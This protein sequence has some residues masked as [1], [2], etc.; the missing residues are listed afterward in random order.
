MVVQC[1]FKLK[2]L[3]PTIIL[4]I[5]Y[6]PHTSKYKNHK[7]VKMDSKEPEALLYI[8]LACPFSPK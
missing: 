5:K 6:P 7:G 8:S 1:L 2:K 3:D 4:K